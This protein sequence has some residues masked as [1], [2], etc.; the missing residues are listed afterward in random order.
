MLTHYVLAHL[1]VRGHRLRPG[2]MAGGRGEL[3]HGRSEGTRLGRPEAHPRLP[4]ARGGPDVPAPAAAAPAVAAAASPAA[5]AAA[6]TSRAAAA[7]ADARREIERDGSRYTGARRRSGRGERRDGERD[8]VRDEPRVRSR[9]GRGRSRRAGDCDGGRDGGRDPI[10]RP[11]GRA[12]QQSVQALAR[13]RG[14][15]ARRAG[16]HQ[17]PRGRGSPQTGTGHRFRRRRGGGRGSHW[18]E[19]RPIAG[20]ARR[21]QPCVLEA[22]NVCTGGCNRMWPR[23]L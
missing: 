12:R 9:D 11:R 7:A 23:L 22:A 8:G 20:G 5:A 4:A 17:R 13:R 16:V 6:A 19:A 3:S 18:R 14:Q 10:S 1:D 21:L 2:G 15:V